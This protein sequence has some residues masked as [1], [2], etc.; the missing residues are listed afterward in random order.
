MGRSCRQY[1]AILSCIFAFYFSLFCVSQGKDTL[2]VNESVLVY[3]GD[4]LE[5]SNQRFRLT[6]T[7][8]YSWLWF[9]VI[10]YMSMLRSIDVWASDSYQTP[11]SKEPAFLTMNADGRLVVYDTS[12][13]PVIVV[14]SEQPIMISNTTAILLDNGNLVLR[15]PGGNTVWQSF[16]HPSNKWLQGMKLGILQSGTRFLTSSPS[17]NQPSSTLG[18]DLNNTREITITQ[19]GV[20]YWRSGTWDGQKLSFLDISDSFGFNFY[21]VSTPNETYFT[22]NSSTDPF[23][24]LIFSESG[25]ITVSSGD[26]TNAQVLAVCDV[27]TYRTTKDQPKG[28]TNSCGVGDGFKE[29]M[30]DL[31]AWDE[32]SYNDNALRFCKLR[33]RRNCSCYAYS[34]TAYDQDGVAMGCKMAI[35]RHG[36]LIS[37]NK[38][39]IFARE[40]FVL[41]KGKFEQ[42]YCCL[43]YCCL[44]CQV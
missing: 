2:G 40:S 10:Q 31:V 36:K 9:L 32:V 39:T 6:I 38:Q 41:E 25:N 1:L 33:C 22:W 15:A 24:L 28:C 19:D 14:N 20:V 29:I 3:H 37:S 34:N 27:I 13:S 30:G 23:A 43:S 12:H 44:I 42:V 7:H 16:D 17:Y 18:V 8:P 4:L 26:F 35:R 5:S 11:A 21:Y